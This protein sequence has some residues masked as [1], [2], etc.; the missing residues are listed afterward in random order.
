MINDLEIPDLTYVKP[1]PF[2]LA[3]YKCKRLIVAHPNGRAIESIQ[4]FIF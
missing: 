2:V 1:S 4:Q 3:R